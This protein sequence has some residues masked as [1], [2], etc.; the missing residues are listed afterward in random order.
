MN[1]LISVIVPVYN[2]APY[3]DECLLSIVNQSYTDLEIILVDDGSTD[4]SERKCDEWSIKDSRVKVIH[5][6][7]SGLSAAR[8]VGIDCAQG[9]YI[10]FV[11]SDDYVTTDEIKTLYEYAIRYDADLT[12]GC[13]RWVSESGIPI[14]KA[15]D[16][17]ETEARILSKE[18]F[19]KEFCDDPDYIVAWSK[20]YR[21]ELFEA[22][23]FPIGVIN[24]DFGIARHIIEKADKILYTGKQ[25]YYYR[26]RQGSIGRSPFSEKNL[27]LIGERFELLKYILAQDF[28][29]ETKYYICRRQFTGAIEGIGDG[30]RYL[31]KNRE[32][33]KTLISYY[34]QYK[35]IASMLLTGM[36][37]SV[38]TSFYN[39]AMMWLYLHSRRVFFF[40]RGIKKK[41]L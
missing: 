5:Q 36:G 2:V 27:Y 29:E 38:A 13:A 32:I 31:S 15:E 8:N 40:V 23:R 28:G 6:D 10:V 19:W 34:K 11:D 12:I 18:E 33:T 17:K 41:G 30:F 1:E 22:I 9:D 16:I 39:K 7:N 20:L 37:G 4:G 21:K 14:G 25:I 3:L 24:E 35:S 26:M